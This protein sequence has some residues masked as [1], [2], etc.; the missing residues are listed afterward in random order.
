MLPG[1]DGFAGEE[2]ALPDNCQA[3]AEPAWPACAPAVVRG[4]SP[5]SSAPGEKR[6]GHLGTAVLT[7]ALCFP[8]T[9]IHSYTATQKTV[10]GPS[11][12]AWRDGRGAHQNIIPASTGAASAVGKVIPELKGYE[13]R[14]QKGAGGGGPGHAPGKG[15]DDVP[16]F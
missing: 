11:K 3:G 13:A 14:G 9:T 6:Q 5:T 16:G 7:L 12:K 10:D 2:A 4:G 15:T 8:E 1:R